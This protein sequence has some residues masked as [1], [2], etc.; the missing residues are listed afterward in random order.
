MAAAFDGSMRA[1]AGLKN[2]TSQ[3]I[4]RLVGA[5]EDATRDGY[6]AGPLVRYEAE[7]LVPRGPGS[8]SPR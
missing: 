2:L 8:R 5:A 6:G 7:L 4:G 1:L 3:L